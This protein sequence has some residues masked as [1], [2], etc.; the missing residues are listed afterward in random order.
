MNQT[1]LVKGI[2]VVGVLFAAFGGFLVGIAPPQAADA[3]F[4]VGISS[5]FALIILLLVS[6]LARKKHRRAWITAAVCCLIL[7]IVASYYYKVSYNELTFEYPP[8]NPKVEYVAGTELTPLAQKER[9]DNP[10]ISNAKLLAGFGGPRFIFKVWP[11]ASVNAARKRL[12][13]AYVILVTGLASSIFSLTE[14]TLGSASTGVVRQQ[15]STSKRKRRP[16]PA[17]TVRPRSVKATTTVVS[18]PET[19]RNTADAVSTTDVQGANTS[20]T[21]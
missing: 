15:R 19:K 5:F 3:R 14:G 20:G 18:N 10:G 17:E 4:A 9:R 8:G 13:F 21:D 7:A 1:V 12:I 2:E 6:S 16:R 11:E